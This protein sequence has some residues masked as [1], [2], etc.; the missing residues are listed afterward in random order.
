MEG[1]KG[2]H[3]F[4]ECRNQGKN[5]SQ[6]HYCN[7]GKKLDGALDYLYSMQNH[8][9]S[10]DNRVLIRKQLGAIAEDKF[11]APAL[12]MLKNKDFAFCAAGLAD[13]WM[14]TGDEKIFNAWMNYVKNTPSQNLSWVFASQMDFAKLREA[15]Q[16]KSASCYNEQEIIDLLKAKALNDT[17]SS[18]GRT[19]VVKALITAGNK[20]MLE[21]IKTKITA[22][23]GGSDDKSIIETIDKAISDM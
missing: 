9:K 18:L 13:W 1:D 16:L 22:K 6:Y 11:L 4:G 3:E 23:N 15:H 8:D 17:Y 10:T 5:S 7:W 14:Q 19:V 21:E 2:S 12:E 20:P